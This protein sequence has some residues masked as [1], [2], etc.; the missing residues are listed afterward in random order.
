MKKKLML[1][2]MGLFTLVSCEKDIYEDGNDRMEIE[3]YSPVLD[4]G[5]MKLSGKVSLSGEFRRETAKV[6]FCVTEYTEEM[7][8][9]G[10][11]NGDIFLNGY[12]ASPFDA[13]LH[14]VSGGEYG[15]SD[16]YLWADEI[17]TDGSFSV[18][19]VPQQKQY[20]CIAFAIN[21]L[22]EKGSSYD[23]KYQVLSTK[24]FFFTG[25]ATA[26]L[27][28]VHSMLRNFRLTFIGDQD[29]E[30]G[31]CWSA[32]NPF[33]NV[34]DVCETG[35]WD[36]SNSETGTIVSAEFENLDF[37][38]NE[39]VYLRG[40]LKK[41]I[42]D[43]SSNSE[44]Y[45]MVYS[46]VIEFSTKDL[47]VNINSKEDL[48]N[49]IKSMYVC[50]DSVNNQYEDRR[51]DIWNNFYGKINVNY[52]AQKV[53]WLDY[54]RSNEYGDSAYFEIP[55]VNCTI[56][57]KGVIPYINTISESGKIS[58]MTLL[59]C[60]KNYGILENV[61]SSAI[62]TNYGT[63]KGGNRNDFSY[64]SGTISGATYVW[65]GSNRGQLLNSNHIYVGENYGLVQGCKEVYGTRT[66]DE[67]EWTEIL[68]RMVGN[69]CSEGRII[70]CSLVPDEDNSNLICG[71]NQ[72]Y[73][74]N[75]LPDSACCENNYGVI[76]HS[77]SEGN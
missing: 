21:V 64:N 51:Y 48:Q 43:Y 46:N 17:G 67:Y 56:A 58:D 15:Y 42:S 20:M 32:T 27:E 1:L 33:P 25:E 62:G 55:V 18:S 7:G 49:F 66:Y 11:A 41:Y 69:N 31:L 60:W 34:E 57:G 24:P 5:V 3:Q 72:G 9:Y 19:F 45:K 40:Y 26:Q 76:K 12:M 53:D 38:D 50:R 30:V 73:I 8:N 70:N 75:C 77:T 13:Y 29:L 10:F 37:G 52:E 39:R 22:D 63:V 74:E 54:I 47:E 35:Y 61:D 4:N 28:L 71:E 68:N 65:I 23:S 14:W 59:D 2:L 44:S 6:G 36:Y 16:G